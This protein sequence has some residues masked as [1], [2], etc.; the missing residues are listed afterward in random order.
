MRYIHAEVISNYAMS[1]HDKQELGVGLIIS[2]RQLVHLHTSK[3]THHK[4]INPHAGR[5]ASVHD[6]STDSATF[7]E[8]RRK[9]KFNLAKSP[10]E[11]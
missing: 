9:L 10:Q 5:Y 3:L 6:S 4:P 7:A 2:S 1:I 8:D 11:T